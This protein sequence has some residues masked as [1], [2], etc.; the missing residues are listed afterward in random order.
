MTCMDAIKRDRANLFWLEW[1]AVTEITRNL[2][3][4]YTDHSIIFTVN[5]VL[6]KDAIHQ[7]DQR[8]KRKNGG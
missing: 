4:R 3:T 1:E 5:P 2:L 8:D 7:Q 6:L